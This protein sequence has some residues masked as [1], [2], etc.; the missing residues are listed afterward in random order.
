MRMKKYLA[1]FIGTLVLTGMGCGSAML[2]GCEAAGGHL[3][4][5]LTFGLSVVAMAYAIGS[6]SGCHLNPAV[7]LA[8][9]MCER[10]S[11]GEFIGYILAQCLGATAGAALLLVGTTVFAMPDLTGAL[12]ANG[13]AGAGG[14]AGAALVEI[15]LTFIFILTI[16]GVT[17]RKRDSGIAGMVIGLSL[18][19]VH[20]VGIPL[21]GSSVNPARSIGPALFAG[22]EA[23]Q[24]L[25]VFI[26]APMVGA[27]VAAVMF[28]VMQPENGK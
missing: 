28:K 25:P 14:L 13:I 6:V 1:E 9:L 12:G 8:M 3:A 27:V 5:A 23:L 21:T 26:L 16:L 15:A 19:F 7:S 22:G 2:L 17:A 4:V 11:T 20:L 10:M 18:T 24:Q